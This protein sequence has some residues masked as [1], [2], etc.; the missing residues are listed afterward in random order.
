MSGG[1]ENGF[2][3]KVPSGQGVTFWI[4]V[5]WNDT[6]KDSKWKACTGGS[7]VRLKAGDRFLFTADIQTSGNTKIAKTAAEKYGFTTYA[8]VPDN[9]KI[10]SCFAGV[11]YE[12]TFAMTV[13]WGKSLT[14]GSFTVEKN[15]V[16]PAAVR[17]P[18]R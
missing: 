9:K 17:L 4:C 3:V 2:S 6:V 16:N 14:D 12:Y 15:P 7:T 5:T 13:D 10:Q 1:T 11:L 18:S 8:V